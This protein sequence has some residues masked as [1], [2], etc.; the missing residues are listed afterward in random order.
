MT[1]EDPECHIDVARLSQGIAYAIARAP[2]PSATDTPLEVADRLAP[3][4]IESGWLA[5]SPADGAEPE[6]LWSTAY[7]CSTHQVA[8]TARELVQGHASP[9]DGAAYIEVHTTACHA[10]LDGDCSWSECPQTRDGEPRVTGRHCP[11]DAE[12]VKPWSASPADGAGVDVAGLRAFLLRVENT[13][14]LRHRTPHDHGDC[15]AC[16]IKDEA[17]RLDDALAALEG[18]PDG[19]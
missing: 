7:W 5:A 8:H 4:V 9:A 2:V 11:L 13:G 10:G 15:V 18:A 6:S 12:A 16:S 19:G 14:A 1:R 17:L 3:L